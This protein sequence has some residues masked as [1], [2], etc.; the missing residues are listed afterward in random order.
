MLPGDVVEF[1]VAGLPEDRGVNVILSTPD[2]L[3]TLC[4][5]ARH[6]CVLPTE[7]RAATEYKW[8]IRGQNEKG[9]ISSKP[10]VF[11]TPDTA[12]EIATPEIPATGV[13]FDGRLS[14]TVSGAETDTFAIFEPTEDTEESVATICFGSAPCKT[15]SRLLAGET[16]RV[17]VRAYDEQGL[18]EEIVIDD[19]PV[20][21]PPSSPGAE[22]PTVGSEVAAG[23]VTLRWSAA[24]DPEGDAV[25][26]VVSFRSATATDWTSVSTGTVREASV[27]IEPAGSIF[28]RVTATDALGNSQDSPYFHFHAPQSPLPAVAI[29]PVKSARVPPMGDVPF[30]W[31]PQIHAQHTVWVRDPAG[32]WKIACGGVDRC[33]YRG[34]FEPSSVHEWK[35]VTSAGHFGTA[36]SPLD[37]FRAVDRIVFIHGVLTGRGLWDQASSYLEGKGFVTMN[38]AGYEPDGDGK[39]GIEDVAI[40]EVRSD[41]GRVL[42]AAGLAHGTPII[43]VGHGIG[44]LIARTLSEDPT[45]PYPVQQI[46]TL[47]T[48]HNGDAVLFLVNQGVEFAIKQA[49]NGPGVIKVI[50]YVAGYAYDEWVKPW[51]QTFWDAA[52]WSG[53][54]TDVNKGTPAVPYWAIV[55]KVGTVSASSGTYGA[56]DGKVIDTN[57][58]GL[59][60]RF[61]VH[62]QCSGNM[63]GMRAVIAWI[64]DA[65]P[66][67]A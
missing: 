2:G 34:P 55:G 14:W 53:Y 44:G 40:T 12:L 6:D 51:K 11:R 45:F 33:T 46:V 15:S 3:Q 32:S 47:G 8:W 18:Y 52:P 65:P 60:G 21:R 38:A 62:E 39:Q 48:G 5:A 37:S 25:T 58:R 43:F 22:F 17:L 41:I 31:I 19:V 64:S 30:I 20:N 67:D 63:A 56:V 23:K 61:C 29:F 66:E 28:W 35:I 59:V 26:Y 13:P 7:L 49:K 57:H 36:E 24:M 16:Y 50:G 9:T 1:E 42:E 54:I 27:T 10:F 4:T